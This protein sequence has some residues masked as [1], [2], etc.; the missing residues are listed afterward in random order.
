V[1]IKQILAP[2]ER[3]ALT[4]LKA[5]LAKNRPRPPLF[6]LPVSKAWQPPGDGRIFLAARVQPCSAGHD[7]LDKSCRCPDKG[8]VVKVLTHTGDDPLAD[9]VGGLVELGFSDDS[10][11]ALDVPAELIERARDMKKAF[12]GDSQTREPLSGR[13]RRSLFRSATPPAARLGGR[14]FF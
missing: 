1:N 12:H 13:F 14:F 3:A 2:E 6:T 5:S 8:S 9:C 4:K 11:T 7:P 10:I